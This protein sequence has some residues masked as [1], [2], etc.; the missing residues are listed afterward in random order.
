MQHDGEEDDKEQW[1]QTTALLRAIRD[2]EVRRYLTILDDTCPHAFMERVDDGDYH[3][4]VD[5]AADL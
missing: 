4:K 3:D 1:S 5:R 2:L